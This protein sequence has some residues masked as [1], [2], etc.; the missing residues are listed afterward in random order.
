M[1]VTPGHKTKSGK[2]DWVFRNVLKPLETNTDSTLSM[3]LCLLISIMIGCTVNDEKCAYVPDT[4]EISVDLDFESLSDAFVNINSKEELV[5]LLAS[6]P[7]LRDYLF[8]REEYPN[9]SIFLN[10][11]YS[12]F[13]NPHIDTLRLEVARVFGDEKLLKE[14]FTQAF[15]NLKHY[16]PEVR[17]PKIQT[18]ISGLDNDMVVMDSLIIVS[19]DYFLGPGA[20]YRP[21]MYDYLLRQYIKENIVP[22]C[23][24]LYGISSNFNVTNPADKT[25]LA[26]MIAYG[27]AFYFAKQMV[28]CTPDSVFIGYTAEEIDGSRK[29]QDLIWARFIEDQVLYSTNH[30]VKQK[31]LSERPKTLE[32]GEKCPGR[33]AQ[34]VGWEIVKSYMAS[35]P[36][37][38][39]PQLMQHE[40]ADKLFKESKYKPVRK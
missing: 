13:T 33:I 6:H 26:D 3:L 5:A 1:S 4:S 36:H 38:S 12:R 31:F 22:S 40:N 32:V 11:L 2:T 34:W 20:R 16:Y 28:P 24:L 21:D 37:V 19:L 7:T 23:M 15:K 18:T 39:L 35:H 30:M 14:E 25:V 8:R 17:L 27:K 29:N 10:T 9:D